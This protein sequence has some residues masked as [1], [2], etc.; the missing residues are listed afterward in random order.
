MIFH[1]TQENFKCF[2]S[3]EVGQGVGDICQT[4]KPSDALMWRLLGEMGAE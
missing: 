2:G 4:K 1:I 3:I